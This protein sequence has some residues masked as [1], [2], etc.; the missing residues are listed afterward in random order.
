MKEDIK[1][2]RENKRGGKKQKREIKEVGER[3]KEE[4]KE[5]KLKKLF[6]MLE[7]QGREKKRERDK[8]VILP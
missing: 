6:D 8:K 1:R 4:E 2:M 5:L 7:H 3:I